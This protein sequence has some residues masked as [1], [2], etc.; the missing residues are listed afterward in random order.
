[1][2]A[3]VTL[4]PEVLVGFTGGSGGLTDRHAVANIQITGI[5]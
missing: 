5:P 2:S 4:P 3:Q 1:V